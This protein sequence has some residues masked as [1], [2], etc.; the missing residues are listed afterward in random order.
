MNGIAPVDAMVV[1]ARAML[2]SLASARQNYGLYQPGHPNREEGAGE[3]LGLMREL[4]EASPRE[5]D[6]PVLFVTRHSFYLGT[7]LMAQE[8][9]SLYRLIEAF[10][11]SAIVAL[12]VLPNVSGRDV[13]ALLRVLGGEPGA[14]AEMDGLAV[15][16]VSP[17][18][19]DEDEDEMSELRRHYGVGLELLRQ[20][21]ARV[22]AGRTV[23][24]DLTTQVVQQMADQIIEDPTQAL[25]L[26]TVKSYDE[27]TYYHMMNVCMLSL[28]LG[29][30][31][32][33]TRDQVLAL[34]IGGL[35]HDVGKVNVPA[36]VLQ[37]SG[38][39]DEEQWRLIQRHPLEGAGMLFGTSDGLYHPAVSV[40]LEH[41]SAFDL[42]GYPSLSGRPHPSMPARMVAVADCFDAVT[43]DRPY[44]KAE[45]RRQALNILQSESG[46][47]YDPHVVR[48]F[49][50][51][52]GVF[53][54]GS[55]VQL[56]SGEIGIVVRNHE[57]LLARP[58]IRMVL[59]ASGNVA[60]PDELDLGQ[61]LPDGGFRWVVER[62]M[63]PHEID[64]DVSTLLME[65]KVEEAHTSTEEEAEF[66]AGVADGLIH[67]PG[68]G[69]T[70]PDDYV[71]TH[72]PHG[73]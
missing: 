26:T 55:L 8:S 35:L 65:G 72:N 32:G 29:C 12:E 28:A 1:K 66:D 67:E 24:L 16:R 10:E 46:R 19:T 71:D 42:S 9:L 58:T 34:G 45:E 47:G 39:L 48:T 56:S 36:D 4:R 14:L 18:V 7:A 21:A 6:D 31:V 40:V 33:L 15:N 30:A 23:D 43:T 57:Q 53:P 41:H 44:R 54:V 27:Y 22:A 38:P 73:V 70:P 5:E 25:L 69:E 2:R 68:I 60:E 59:D 61:R 37:K 64:L 63:D 17:D 13:D 52:L 49:V 50:R 3:I 11:K 51:L 20:T 62:S